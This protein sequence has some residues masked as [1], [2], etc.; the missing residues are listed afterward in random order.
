[1]V[2]DLNLQTSIKIARH[3][4]YI[5]TCNSCGYE[6]GQRGLCPNCYQPLRVVSAIPHDVKN[7]FVR[8]R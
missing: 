1:M 6:R 7:H 4:M 3:F 5:F 2:H 8:V